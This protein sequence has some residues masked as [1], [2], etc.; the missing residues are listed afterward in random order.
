MEQLG[1]T[2]AFAGVLAYAIGLFVV[3]GYLFRMGV[4]DFALLRARVVYTGVLVLAFVALAAGWVLLI[5]QLLLQPRQEHPPVSDWRRASSLAAQAL[6]VFGSFLPPLTLL[7]VVL[8]AEDAATEWWVILQLFVSGVLLTLMVHGVLAGDP[9]PTGA[10]ATTADPP[11]GPA[12]RGSGSTRVDL[13]QA[14][15]NPLAFF[16]VGSFLIGFLLVVVSWEAYPIIPEQFGGGRPRSARL[17]VDSAAGEG[18]EALGVPGATGVAS[19]CVELTFVTEDAYML[20]LE[21]GSVVEVPKDVVRAILIDPRSG[22]RS[23]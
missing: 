22:S 20:R 23:C 6:V 5:R 21:S 11:T 4:S 2:V 15:R 13:K 18:L 17:V 1:R 8:D 12:V 9:E 14:S 3:N 16:T 7:S 19:D 10:P